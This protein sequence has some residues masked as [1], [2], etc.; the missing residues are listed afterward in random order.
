[1]Q[2]IKEKE[3]AAAV[4]EMR[5]KKEIDMKK[6]T[7]DTKGELIPI[8]PLP[9]DKLGIEFGFIRPNAR[10]IEIFTNNII[11]TDKSD[12]NHTKEAKG[13][14]AHRLE[15]IKGREKGDVNSVNGGGN[16]AAMNIKKDL[17]LN[18]KEQI[19]PV[20]GKD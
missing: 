5:I 15:E 16:N 14:D 11:R 12:V 9:I 1:K 7:F 20:R 13:K 2:E 4:V 6:Y 19:V 3:K 8:K 17:H 18:T 10:D